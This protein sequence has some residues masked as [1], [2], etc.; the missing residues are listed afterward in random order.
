MVDACEIL[1]NEFP[2][3][4]IRRKI[5]EM[6]REIEKGF[7]YDLIVASYVLSD[8]T[9]DYER[10]VITTAL[11]ELLSDKGCLVLVDRGSSW[12]SFQI[13]SARQFILDSVLFDDDTEDIAR[14]L[15]P[16]PHHFECP[17]AG[18][19]WC[20]FVQ[21]APRTIYPRDASTKRWHGNKG[22]KF[23]Y[24]VVEKNGQDPNEQKQSLARM[25]RGPLLATRHVHLDLCTPS[26]SFKKTFRVLSYSHTTY[27]V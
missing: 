23:S 15:A 7:K 9:N 17:A 2:G 20:H 18:N 6:K 14:I 25:I 24:V 5:T 26:V 3:L 19:T 12:G 22:S 27:W 11:W 21:R 8:I 10:I 4:S 13:R 16:C 1:M